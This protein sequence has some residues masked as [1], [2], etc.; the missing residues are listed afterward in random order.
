M[1]NFKKSRG[2]IRTNKEKYTLKIMKILGTASLGYSFTGP[3]KK[4]V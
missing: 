4:R 3:Y 1:E 2:K